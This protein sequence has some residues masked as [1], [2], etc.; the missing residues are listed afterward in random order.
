LDLAARKSG[1]RTGI[2][3]YSVVAGQQ[4]GGEAG[5][6]VGRLVKKLSL[7]QAPADAHTQGHGMLPG[8]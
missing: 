2:G 4:G 3:Y 5:N 8:T 6:I 7:R 1:Y